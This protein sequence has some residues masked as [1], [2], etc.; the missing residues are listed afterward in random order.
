MAVWGGGAG[1]VL[2]H[3][4][5]PTSPQSLPG[6]ALTY[7]SVDHWAPESMLC[8]TY[9]PPNSLKVRDLLLGSQPCRKSG[10]L[11]RRWDRGQGGEAG[12][13]PRAGG[14]GQREGFCVEPNKETK[15]GGI[16]AAGYEEGDDGAREAQVE[17]RPGL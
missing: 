9:G 8:A 14:L 13:E 5:H 17:A 10:W 15:C 4:S 1:W 12:R 16:W 11:T 2:T 3:L 7:L 6:R